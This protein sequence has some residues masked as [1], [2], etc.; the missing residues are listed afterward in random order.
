[1][2]VFTTQISY[3]RF[4]GF[5][6]FGENTRLSSFDSED[7][8]LEDSDDEVAI[9][10]R[11]HQVRK[12][13]S[14]SESSDNEISKPPSKKPETGRSNNNEEHTIELVDDNAGESSTYN[15]ALAWKNRAATML[16]WRNRQLQTLTHVF[17]PL[18]YFFMFIGVE[19]LDLMVENLPRVADHMS[20]NRFETIK[21][22]IHFF[23]N[24]QMKAAGEPGYD[25]LYKIGP[26]FD[27]DVSNCKKHRSQ[28]NKRFG[29]L[30]KKN[31]EPSKSL[32]VCNNLEFYNSDLEEPVNLQEPKEPY[33]NLNARKNHEICTEL[34][35]LQEDTNL[36]SLDF[37]PAEHFKEPEPIAEGSALIN[38]VFQQHFIVLTQ[39]DSKPGLLSDTTS[40]EK[41]RSEQ[42]EVLTSSPYKNELLEKRR[43]AEERKQA[44]A[45]RKLEKDAK[46][47]E[48]CSKGG[49]LGAY[50]LSKIADEGDKTNKK[51]QKKLDCGGNKETTE[52]N[53]TCIICLESLEEESNDTS[54][55]TMVEVLTNKPQEIEIEG[56]RIIS[57]NEEFH[58]DTDMD[59]NTTAV[60]GIMSIGCGQKKKDA[61]Y[62]IYCQ[63]PDMDEEEYKRKKSQFLEKLLKIDEERDNFEKCTILQSSCGTWLEERRKLITASNFH[64]VCCRRPTTSCSNLVKRLLYSGEIIAPAVKH[65]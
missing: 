60:E 32:K 15:K 37:I 4:Y 49:K 1:M 58:N 46:K 52:H 55:T 51:R 10:Q 11:R 40:T 45:K 61:D 22:N 31:L 21:A 56:R 39:A 43:V 7:S 26:L 65:A 59:I 20:V 34:G 5:T 57:T 36:V 35:A 3:I 47:D 6:K 62:G 48:M 17:S 64:D 53:T 42:N 38:G 44:A 8:L 16:L 28:V 19:L 24:L 13:V 18:D 33:K 27:H 9:S 30:C 23:D 63:Q 14:E 12:I 50:Q 54:S 2:N 29:Q 25:R 41:R